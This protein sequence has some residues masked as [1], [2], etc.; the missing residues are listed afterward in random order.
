MD[1][2]TKVVL[3]RFARA[4]IAGA[5]STMALITINDVNNWTDLAYAINALVIS[6]AVGGINGLL[7]AVDKLAR[8]K[9]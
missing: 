8:W 6:G 7:L 2:K 5:L 9:E 3:V 1:I 4:F